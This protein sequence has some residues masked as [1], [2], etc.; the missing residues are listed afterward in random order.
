[1]KGYV[2]QDC[3]WVCSGQLR[4]GDD[5]ASSTHFTSRYTGCVIFGRVVFLEDEL[6]L[7]IRDDVEQD[8]TPS[9]EER[10]SSLSIQV[11]LLHFLFF[12]WIPFSRQ[13]FLHYFEDYYSSRSCCSKSNFSHHRSKWHKLIIFSKHILFLAIMFWKWL[14]HPKE[15]WIESF[16]IESMLPV[17]IAVQVDQNDT[18]KLPPL[19]AIIN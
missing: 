12:S 18:T 1:M 7:R 17:K 3:S 16:L 14:Y 9:W 13:E 19:D 2:S 4:R 11:S 10:P 5:S 6:I 8:M 15:S